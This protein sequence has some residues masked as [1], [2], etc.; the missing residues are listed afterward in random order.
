M[1]DVLNWC[2]V[3]PR[4]ERAIIKGGRQDKHRQDFHLCLTLVGSVDV[5]LGVTD[6]RGVSVS[7]IAIVSGR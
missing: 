2:Y 5:L 3:N 1:N 6:L 7:V 4:M